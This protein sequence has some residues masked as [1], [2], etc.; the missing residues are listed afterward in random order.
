MD[1]FEAKEIPG[2]YLELLRVPFLGYVGAR[3]WRKP[4]ARQTNGEGDRGSSFFVLGPSFLA[5]SFQVAA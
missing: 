4:K 2:A 1:Q 3:T 5:V